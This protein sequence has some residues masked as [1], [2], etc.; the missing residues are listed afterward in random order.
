MHRYELVET[1]KQSRNYL[2]APDDHAGDAGEAEGVNGPEDDGDRR[3]RI[4][5][6]TVRAAAAGLPKWLLVVRPTLK[7]RVAGMATAGLLPRIMGFG[8]GAPA[9]WCWPRPASMLDQM[10][11][12]ELNVKPSPPR[13]WPWCRPGSSPTT[14]HGS[15]P[16]V[17]PSP[18]ATKLARAAPGSSPPA[19]MNSHRCGGR[20]CAMHHV[21]RRGGMGIAMIIERV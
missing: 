17:A 10:D 20:A 7:A 3:Q 2:W 14:R 4:R 5:R 6:M 19:I 21:H 16:T 8:P 1:T 18:W 11:V 15:I 13:P 12:I 9:A